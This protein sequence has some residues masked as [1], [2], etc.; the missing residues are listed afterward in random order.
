MLCLKWWPKVLCS[1]PLP[2]NNSILSW[3]TWAESVLLNMGPFWQSNVCLSLKE[4][5]HGIKT[6]RDFDAWT[7]MKSRLLSWSFV[8][9]PVFVTAWQIH[10]LF[11]YKAQQVETLSKRQLSLSLL[12]MF[13]ARVGFFQK[14]YLVTWRTRW[15]VFYRGIWQVFR[16]ELVWKRAVTLKKYFAGDWTNHPSMTVNLGWT[17]LI[18]PTAEV[19]Y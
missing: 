14:S 1:L 3:L 10:L 2:T 12:H 18:R 4:V 8:V 9:E 19:C 15:F 13:S 7:N 11:I 6:V 16:I 17:H 5:G